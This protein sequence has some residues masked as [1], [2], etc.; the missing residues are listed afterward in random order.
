MDSDGDN[1]Y[2]SD[3][4]QEAVSEVGLNF[5]GDQDDDDRPPYLVSVFVREFRSVVRSFVRAS[6]SRLRHARAREQ[7]FP[8]EETAMSSRGEPM[9]YD[10]ASNKGT[11][12]MAISNKL[13]CRFVF[14]LFSSSVA[15]SLI[16][17]RT[18]RNERQLTAS[19]NVLRHAP[20]GSSCLVNIALVREPCA[21]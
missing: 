5:E 21:R 14:V 20:T 13:A 19:L 12:V 15:L 1:L 2:S 16:F 6:G 8:V 3:S 17:M 11:C 18:N 9:S 10:D 7:P 4:D